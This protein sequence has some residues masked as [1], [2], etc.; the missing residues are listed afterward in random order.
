MN[1]FCFANWL[2]ENYPPNVRFLQINQAEFTFWYFLWYI[3][4]NSKHY[5]KKSFFQNQVEGKR[6]APFSYC[7]DL[8]NKI[9]CLKSTSFD[10]VCRHEITVQYV[11]EFIA[12]I[13]FWF[14][15]KTMSNEIENSISV[16]SSH[17]VSNFPSNFFT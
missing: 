12:L 14:W 8:N 11:A 5:R 15:K 3:A 17:I 2:N 7:F 6:T 4:Q 13:V 10:V 16:V 9:K 1:P